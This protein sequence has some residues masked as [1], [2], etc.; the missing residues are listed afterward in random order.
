MIKILRPY[1][2]LFLCIQNGYAQEIKLGIHV[3]TNAFQ[4]VDFK[5]PYYKPEGSNYTYTPEKAGSNSLINHFNVANNL[6]LGANIR[7]SRKKLGLNFEPEILLE[8]IQLKFNAPYLSERLMNKKSLRLPFFGTYYLFKNINTPYLILGGIWSFE[9]VYDFQR[10]SNNYYTGTQEG[11]YEDKVNFGDNHF[12]GVFY[13]T[14]QKF[15]YQYMIG[16]GQQVKKIN[17]SARYVNYVPNFE[18]LIENNVFRGTIWQ[19]EFNL[20]Y[21][22]LSNKDVTK[23]NYLYEE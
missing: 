10:P 14:E 17:M 1:L 6:K 21:Y 23:K 7:F 8:I 18:N 15:R 19:I 5:A 9:T 4:K 13:D 11:V 2:L 3:G 20:S 22:F 16:I 12:E